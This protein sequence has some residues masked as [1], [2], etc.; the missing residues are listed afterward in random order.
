M[1]KNVSDA[2]FDAEVLGSDLPV[3]VDFWAPWCGPCKM[4]GP[5]VEEL[6]KEYEGRLKVV[7]INT[8]D[9]PGVP[10]QMG[11]R[12]IPTLIIFKGSEVA[13]HRVGAA[14][15]ES[16]R[17]MIEGVLNPKPSLFGRLFGGKQKAEEA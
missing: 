7:K 3:L 15:K 16:L 14:P 10:G 1:V 11:V 8:Q 2:S 9:N 5:I 4:V 12:S 17:Q 6:A 13:D